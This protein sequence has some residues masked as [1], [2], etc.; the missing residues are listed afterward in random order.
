MLESNPPERLRAQ[1]LSGLSQMSMWSEVQ[2]TTKGISCQIVGGALR[3]LALGVRP[4]DLDIIVEHSGEAIWNRL[5]ASLPAKAVRL[6]RDRFAAF[7]LVGAGGTIDIWDRE[8]VDLIEDLA[9]R[10]FTLHSFAIDIDSGKL[11]DPFNGTRDLGLRRLVATTEN[12]F[13]GDPLRALRLCRFLAQIDRS[14]TDQATLS[15]ARESVPFLEGVAT[16]RVRCELEQLLALPDVW[17]GLAAMISLGIYPRLFLSGRV[18]NS[19]EPI[20]STMN[21]DERL[22]LVETVAKNLSMPADMPLVRLGLLITSL[23]GGK[24][25]SNSQLDSSW[26]NRVPIAKSSLRRL[27]RILVW[28]RIPTDHS[29]Q[30][31]FLNQLGNLWPSALCLLVAQDE[32]STPPGPV[33]SSVQEISDL[34]AELG[35]G[36]FS[37]LFLISGIDLQEILGLQPG[38]ELGEILKAVQRQ[39]VEGEITT[40]PEAIELARRLADKSNYR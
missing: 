18:Q 33:A 17:P 27:A 15:L 30:R 1:L 6:G 32:R 8:G 16:E 12:S 22:H 13:T 10:D 25:L 24:A 40:R 19:V 29:E 9:R 2:R 21:L 31:W 14:E 4:D 5:A 3:D 38:E 34:A 7:R 20:V 28:T 23:P 37:P 11:T 26:G 39:Q 35:E 36:I